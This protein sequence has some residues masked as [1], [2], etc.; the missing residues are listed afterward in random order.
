M[1][2]SYER[3]I[4]Q[5]CSSGDVNNDSFTLSVS[6]VQKCTEYINIYSW[7]NMKLMICDEMWIY[8]TVP[9]LVQVWSKLVC[10]NTPMLDMII[11]VH[12]IWM[13]LGW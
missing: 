4:H 5:N 1:V 12:L 11:T 3:S 10:K 8:Y 9:N 13:N 6:F 2:S 7:E